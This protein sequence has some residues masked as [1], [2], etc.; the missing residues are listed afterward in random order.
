MNRTFPP[1]AK[2]RLRLRTLGIV[3]AIVFA[4]LTV[5]VSVALTRHSA[6]QHR[7]AGIE[8]LS[9]ADEG[10][11]L[12]I[13]SVSATAFGTE[14]RFVSSLDVPLTNGAVATFELTDL[15]IVVNGTP[16]DVAEWATSVDYGVSPDRRVAMFSIL[17]RALPLGASK[18]R[19]SL[20]AL[21]VVPPD[22]DGVR[23]DGLRTGGATLDSDRLPKVANVA[24]GERTV[25]TGF[26]WRYVIEAVETDSTSVRLTYHVEG[27]VNGVR[28]LP[29]RDAATKANV[30]LVP[31]TG[32]GT[33]VFPR[34]PSDQQ[35]IVYFGGLGRSVDAPA[36]AT[37]ER[38][39]TG[40]A[41][42]DSDVGGAGAYIEVSSSVQGSLDFFSV[43]VT[44]PLSLN[45]PASLG[46]AARL[47]DD[48]D[49]SYSLYHGSSIGRSA[50]RSSWDFEGPIDP[51][52]T[53]LE[54]VVDGYAR[55]EEGDWALTISLGTG[56]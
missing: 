54:F 11:G 10:G 3:A 30:V 6:T 18:L 51:A 40:W 21:Y 14:I 9:T 24:F 47:V 4:A 2:H 48:R 49:T 46:Q 29:P 43:I 12:T 1:E 17:G 26:G 41:V 36:K 56:G 27:D 31:A 38:N 15:S 42:T 34:D 39:A 52:A 20:P 37:F 22:G 44:S 33:V 19:L 23:H 28:P 50:I 7:P 16:L 25:D 13:T 8:M 53:R 5:S 45:G 55:L 32:R 35:L